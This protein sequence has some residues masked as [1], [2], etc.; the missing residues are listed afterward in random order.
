MILR[1]IAAALIFLFFIGCDNSEKKPVETKE[2]VVLVPEPD[3]ELREEYENNQKAKGS[4]CPFFDADTS[5][6]GIELEDAKTAISIIGNKDKISRND[7]YHYYSANGKEILTLNQHPGNG[8]YSMSIFKVEQSDKTDHDYKKL[9]IANF[10]TEK[11]IKLGLSKKQVIEKFGNCYQAKDSSSSKI[12]LYYRI[13]SPND[14]RTKLLKSHNMPIFY[15]S[16]QFK[17]DRLT[18]FEFGFEYP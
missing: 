3:K 17:K 7:Q 10:K 2:R 1:T 16:Y 8:K 18:K 15:A 12:E 9:D 5:V 11:G 6:S 4:A 14:T 13:E